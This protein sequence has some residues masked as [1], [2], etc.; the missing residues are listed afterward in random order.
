MAIREQ[1][2]LRL[3]RDERERLQDY[4][5]KHGCA[6]LSAALRHALPREVFPD[7]IREAGR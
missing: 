5:A 2:G 6:S 7:E 1:I 4:A 3:R